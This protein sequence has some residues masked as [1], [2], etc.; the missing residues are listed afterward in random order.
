MS[1]YQCFSLRQAGWLMMNGFV[2]FKVIDDY[3]ST[4]KIYLF[5]DTE[6]LRIKLKEYKK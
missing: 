2:L 5:N 6:A 1:Y 4:R 3:K